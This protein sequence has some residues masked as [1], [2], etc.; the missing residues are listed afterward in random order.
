MT[1]YYITSGSE[2]ISGPHAID[3]DAVRR[4]THCGNPELLPAA[5]LTSLGV[6]VDASPE[7]EDWSP[8][9]Q[10]AIVGQTVVR[11]IL[12]MTADDLRAAAALLG[13]RIDRAVDDV[14]AAVIGQRHAEY[15]QAETDAQAYATAGYSGTVPASVQCWAT[16]AGLTAQ[17]AANNIL[18]TAAAWRTASQTMRAA[19]LDHK[20]MAKAATSSADLTAVNAS[21]GATI[22]Q[23]RAALGI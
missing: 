14:Y 23:I 20:A 7:G 9:G 6:L 11:P 16:A 10:A 21:W 1:M 15:A 3:S 22:A 13:Q 5:D 19:R 12:T 18:A 8:R 2:V 17:A 4:A